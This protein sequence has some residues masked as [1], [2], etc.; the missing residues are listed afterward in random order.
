MLLSITNLVDFI[1]ELKYD[2]L[3]SEKDNYKFMGNEQLPPSK[4]LPPRDPEKTPEQIPDVR[5]EVK[6]EA[7]E[8]RKDTAP[9]LKEN[10]SPWETVFDGYGKVEYKNGVIT[11]EPKTSTIK[12]KDPKEFQETHAALVVSKEKFKQPFQISCTMKTLKQL[13]QN[14]PAN[15]WEVGWLVFGY[16]DNG[17]DKGKFKY[18]ILK[19]EGL[20]VGESLLN[21]AQEFLYRKETDQD[22]FP[23]NK[24]YNVNLRVENNA[25]TITVNGKKYPPYKMFSGEGNDHLDADGKVGFYPE[26]SKIEIRDIKV[27]QL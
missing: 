27:E 20:E 16:K 18:L 25:V 24:D 14:E 7:K 9:N 5:E 3:S 15:N 8:R 23:I 1:T 22:R 13:R 11:M 12:R 19:P 21:D 4:R 26:D 10:P 6:N 17:P 2:K